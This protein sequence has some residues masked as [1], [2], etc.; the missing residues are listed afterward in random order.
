MRIFESFD[1]RMNDDAGDKAA[2]RDS[3]DKVNIHFG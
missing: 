1:N 2:E 3:I